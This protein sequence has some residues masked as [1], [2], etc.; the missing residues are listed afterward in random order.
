MNKL[1]ESRHMKIDRNSIIDAER[2]FSKI[3]PDKEKRLAT[4]SFLSEAIEFAHSLSPTNWNL[5]LDKNGALIRMNMGKEYSINIDKNTFLIICDRETIKPYLNNLKSEIKFLG[6]N[7]KKKIYSN[8]IDLVPGCLVNVPDSI[9]CYFYL[10]EFYFEELGLFQESNFTFM[11]KASKEKSAKIWIQ[12]VKAHS[13]GAIEYLSFILKKNIPNP[14]YCSK[15]T[16]SYEQYIYNQ[17]KDIKKI[18][19]MTLE[20][21][22]EK[23]K[24]YGPVPEKLLVTQSIFKRNE[25]VVRIV[26]E[27]AKGFCEKCKKEAPFL[28]DKDKLP[29]LEVHHII[30]LSEGGDDTVDNAIALCPNCHRQA[31]Y[32][33]RTIGDFLKMFPI[34]KIK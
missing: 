18:N 4:I 31:H 6:Y 12:S 32:G 15:A 16:I 20:Q 26:H 11:T 8:K 2:F 30:P 7:N 29:Y 19:K 34:T 22:A 28:R 3:F 9:G 25:Y 14:D 21:I 5:N 24:N 10:N 13:P 27:R 1:I 17:E 33:K 23:V